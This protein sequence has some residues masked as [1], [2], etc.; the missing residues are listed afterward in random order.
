MWTRHILKNYVIQDPHRPLSQPFESIVLI[1]AKQFNKPMG[2]SYST[3]RRTQLLSNLEIMFR[4]TGWAPHSFTDVKGGSCKRSRMSAF[5]SDTGAAS[6][7]A[8]YKWAARASAHLFTHIDV[9]L[10]VALVQIEQD[11]GL[12]QI[13]QHGHVLHPIHTCLMHRLDLLLG[14]RESWVAE[15][16]EEMKRWWRKMPNCKIGGS[17]SSLVHKFAPFSQGWWVDEWVS[18]CHKS[19]E[20]TV[21]PL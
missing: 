12:M 15:Y 5:F 7:L 10:L 6:G 18:C 17:F 2:F 9:I 20:S 8:A 16:L 11:G 1:Y 13:P 14:K 19:T 3:S 4:S 21:L